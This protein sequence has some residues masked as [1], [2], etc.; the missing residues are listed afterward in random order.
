MDQQTDKRIES[1]KGRSREGKMKGQK[2]EG[3]T[4]KQMDGKKAR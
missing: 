3:R 1:R 4:N 2:D